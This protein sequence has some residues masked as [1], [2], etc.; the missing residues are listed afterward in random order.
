[1]NASLQVRVASEDWCPTPTWHFVPRNPSEHHRH[2]PQ[3]V[4]LLRDFGT[5]SSWAATSK[6]LLKC[7]FVLGYTTYTTVNFDPTQFSILFWQNAVC[8]SE[9][10]APLSA[11]ESQSHW[12]ALHVGERSAKDPRICASCH[13]SQ[14]S[15]S[16]HLDLGK[17]WVD[18]GASKYGSWHT[19]IWECVWHILAFWSKVWRCSAWS[20]TRCLA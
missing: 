4:T 1:M 15:M 5:E 17:R 11:K 7:M 8:I 3:V 18:I 14:S 20:Q 9:V 12:F 13:T 16:L 19:I 6:A 10:C 2:K